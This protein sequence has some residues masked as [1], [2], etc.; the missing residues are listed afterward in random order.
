MVAFEN[1]DARASVLLKLC[2][3]QLAGFFDGYRGLRASWRKSC[4][5]SLSV[6]LELSE[7]HA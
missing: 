2:F 4:D 3:A 6:R 5:A 1:Q 7:S